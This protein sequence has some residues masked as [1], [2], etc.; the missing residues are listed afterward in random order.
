VGSST[1]L[2]QRQI[3]E[4]LRK[5]EEKFAKLFRASPLAIALISTKNNQHRYLEVNDGFERL[6]GWKRDEVIGRTPFDISIWV[7]PNQ[8]TNLASQLLSGGMVRN[9]EIQ[10]RRRNGEI[11]T[12]LVSAEL[13]EID[14]QPCILSMAADVT[15]LKRAEET[16]LRH[17]VIVESSDDAII[18]KNLEGVIQSWNRGAQRL[19]GYTAT[20]A[21]GRPITIIVPDELRGEEEEI[22]QKV[23]NGEHIERHETVRIT[24]PGKRI[25]VSLTISPISDR[26]G[27]VVGAC[28]IARDITERKKFDQSLLWRL[29]FESLLSELSTTL[30]GLPEEEIDS[31]IERGLA[32]LGEFLKMDRISLY[33]FSGDRTKLAAIYSWS[34][35]GVR[36]A[37]DSVTTND[38][39]WWWDKALHG[40]TTLASQLSDLPDEAAA[41]KEYLRDRGIVSAASIPL[42]VGGDINGAIS[43]VTV[44]RQVSWTA[45]LVN[46]LRAIGEIFWNA[47]KRKHAMEALLTAQAAVRESEERFRLVANAAPVMIW[48]SGVDG[49]CTYF[50]QGWLEFTGRSNDSELGNG[51]TEG[52]YPEDLPQCLDTYTKAFDRREPFAMQY[53]LRR[54]DGEDRWI[55][56]QGV[57][58]FNADGS[59]A[60]Y[61]G[62]CIDVT[63]HKLAEEALSTVSQKLIEAHEE[64]RTRIARE[65]HDDINQRLAL[66]AVQLDEL[67]PGEA[68]K[69]LEDLASDIQALSHRLHSAK[70]EYLGLEAAVA[71][72]CREFSDRQR[73]DIDFHYATVRKNL[74]QAVSVCL[75]RVLQ[76]AL[77]NAIK[78][79]GSRNVQVSFKGEANEIELTVHDSGIGFDPQEAMKGRGLG[80]TSMRE[81]LKLV[82]GE[83]SIDSHSQR[84]TTIHARVPLNPRTNSAGAA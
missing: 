82:D 61:I 32:R 84:G 9:V 63:D 56:D 78:H 1:R 12:A 79:S 14:S 65:L 51:W 72:F 19:F 16:T 29:E 38:L 10:F 71:S 28:K 58:R 41:E 76:E 31:N 68:R 18:S 69:Q 13:V 23:R 64:E 33:E 5:S 2:T 4:A 47:L 8:K 73:V 70:L 25:D 44:R 6:T 55:F 77:Q 80:L 26:S 34:V 46:Q 60:G 42:K 15:D 11:R 59:F 83:L 7:D 66:L 36:K 54:H 45:D 39:P 30:I 3:A 24:K 37:P 62:S 22:L 21:V 75:F 57:P 48:M 40:E 20:E 74:P 67:K 49:L 17:H 50:N 27:K 43:F 35:P 81:R 53:R 52:V